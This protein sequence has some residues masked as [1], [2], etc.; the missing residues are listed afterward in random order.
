MSLGSNNMK[1]WEKPFE[2]CDLLVRLSSG[3]RDFCFVFPVISSS[4]GKTVLLGVLGMNKRL[5]SLF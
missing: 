5:Y 1:I 4:F 2:Q 3:P